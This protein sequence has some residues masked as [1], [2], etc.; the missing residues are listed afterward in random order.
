MKKTVITVII[1]MLLMPVMLFSQNQEALKR[2][3]EQGKS[4]DRQILELYNSIQRVVADNKLME[5]RD[6][7]TLP[8]QTEINFGPDSKNPQYVE[9]IKH[10]YIRDGLFSSKPIGLEEK[11]LRI[12]SNGTTI[13]KLETIIRTKNFKTQEVESVIVTDPSPS[14]ETTD[15]VTFTHQY[16]GK[17]VIEQKKL[18]EVKN[19]VVMPLRNEIKLQFMIPNLTILYNNIF[20]ITESYKEENKSTDSKMSEFIK[21]AIQY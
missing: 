12:Y 21:K 19:N 16:N 5:N 6:I 18:S 3:E 17:T 13:S 9:L 15:D 7:K 2:I 14:S 8:Y 10:I 1:T 4:Y 20:F 11:I